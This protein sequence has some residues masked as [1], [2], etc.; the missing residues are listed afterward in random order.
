MARIA[1]RATI[2]A[3]MIRD[4]TAGALRCGLDVRRLLQEAGLP[5]DL[6]E[7]SDLPE[8]PKRMVTLDQF[9][10]LHRLLM[11]ALDDEYVGLLH[12]PQRL[13]TSAAMGL[14]AV[15]ARTAGEAMKRTVDFYNLF[16]NSFA[17]ALAHEGR[18]ARY[19]LG[20]RPGQKVLN[21]YAVELVLCEIHRFY[22]WL[23]GDRI[24]IDEV[25]F[26][27]SPE[28]GKAAVY[29]HFF[30]GGDMRFNQAE[31][32]IIF[33]EEY[34]NQPVVKS[35]ADL[36]SW[37]ARSPID[38]FLPAHTYGH[39][40][41]SVRDVLN[42]SFGEELQARSLREVARRLHR[43]PQALRRRLQAEKTS[44]REIKE[45]VLCNLAVHL[46]VEGDLAV[47]DVSERLGYSEPSAF[48]RA[49]S[50]WTGMS[51]LRYRKEALRA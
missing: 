38:L 22:S 47:Q 29:P 13:G 20:Y 27:F 2:S 17:H 34:L 41:L 51:P 37:I 10:A 32:S 4:A 46:L 49:F 30:F 11:A 21:N 40:T 28:Q 18:Q 25:R 19:I 35:E 8:H 43:H 14:L 33:S 1:E 3:A 36:A 16:E 45:H 42:S 26:T 9:V 50:K 23:L 5:A 24:M 48:N 44:F 31:N 39:E 12:R 7:R 15:H 6:P